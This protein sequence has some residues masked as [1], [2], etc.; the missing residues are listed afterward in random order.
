MPKSAINGRLVL[1]NKKVK[2]SNNGKNIIIHKKF[3][4]NKVLFLENKNT[5]HLKQTVYFFGVGRM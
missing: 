3:K 2:P 5:L 4:A 1:N